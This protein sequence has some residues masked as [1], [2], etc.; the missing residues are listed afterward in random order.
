MIKGFRDFILRGNVID[1]AVGIV[2]GA[3]FGALVNAFVT[4]LIM[5]PIAAVF[6]KPS[7]DALVLGPFKYGAFLTALVQFLLITVAIY[8]FVVVPMN[9]TMKRLGRLQEPLP[10]RDCPS[11]LQSIPADA[12]KCMYCTVDLPTAPSPGH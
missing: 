3:A 4:N 2:I 10:M 9:A 12:S 1:L 5:A 11:C 8:F 7:F 6:G